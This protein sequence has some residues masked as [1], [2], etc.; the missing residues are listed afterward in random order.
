VFATV[1]FDCSGLMRLQA[2]HVYEIFGC[3]ALT[4]SRYF[5]LNLLIEL[6]I[7]SGEM[8]RLFKDTVSNYNQVWDLHGIKTT[9]FSRYRHLKSQ[10]MVSE[11]VFR[12]RRDDGTYHLKYYTPF[13][14][15]ETFQ[16]QIPKFFSMTEK[17]LKRRAIDHAY[18][19]HS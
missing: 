7:S 2:D 1:G 14:M 17:K 10:K 19:R 8:Q 18:K 9:C 3:C 16:D 6:I 5:N 13:R 15:D 12:E 11:L 4:E